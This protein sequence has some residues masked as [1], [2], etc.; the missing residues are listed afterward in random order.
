MK[1]AFQLAIGLVCLSLPSV[2][3]QDN[4]ELPLA[5]KRFVTQ[6]TIAI[7]H[8]DLEKINFDDLTKWATK[9]GAF[10]DSEATQTKAWVTKNQKA[11]DQFRLAGVRH[12]YTVFVVADGFSE[13]MLIVMPLE[14]PEKVGAAAVE[15][16]LR[17][18]IRS[19]ETDFQEVV[20]RDGVG[21]VGDTKDRIL[22]YLRL[23]LSLIHI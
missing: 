14:E 7:G 4:A 10:N 5:L 8:V 15:A 1:W 17:D 6:D 21:I 12:V 13:S 9:T 23:D 18:A 20:V 2:F 22:D 16:T 11:M 19:Y 3:A